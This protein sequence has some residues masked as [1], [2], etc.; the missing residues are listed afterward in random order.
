VAIDNVTTRFD[1][2]ANFVKNSVRFL[3]YELNS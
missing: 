1:L 2:S 3:G